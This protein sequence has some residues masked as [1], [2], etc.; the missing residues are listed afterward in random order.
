MDGRGVARWPD[1]Q[2]YQGSFRAGM[3][4]GRGSLAFSEGAEYEGRFREDD[5]DGQG[6]LKVT[7]VCAG[8]GEGEKMLPVLIQADIKR[9]HYKAGFVEENHH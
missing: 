1:G 6:T 2:Q 8:A 4:E 7:R 3:R 9:I 5:L